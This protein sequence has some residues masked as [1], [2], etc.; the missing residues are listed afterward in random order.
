MYSCHG[1][2][3]QCQYFIKRKKKKT[4]ENIVVQLCELHLL[5][6]LKGQK[7]PKGVVGDPGIGLPGLDGPQGPRGRTLVASTLS[8]ILKTL[9]KECG[10]FYLE[11]DNSER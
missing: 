11:L 5:S 9:L 3:S 4:F 1:F 10:F 6:F 8:N 7:G 2:Y